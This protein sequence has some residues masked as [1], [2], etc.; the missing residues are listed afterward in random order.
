MEK[1]GFALSAG[2]DRKYEQYAQKCREIEIQFIP[3]A[4]KTVGGFTDTVRKILKKIAT[5]ADNRS[6][7]PAWLSVAFS[8]LSQSVSVTAVRGSAIKL[9]ERDARL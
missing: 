1:I 6:L 4:L 7:Q 9:L 5:L 3:V 2:E 8:R